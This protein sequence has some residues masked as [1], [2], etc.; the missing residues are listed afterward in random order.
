M[1]YQTGYFTDP[2]VEFI[3]DGSGSIIGVLSG[4]GKKST[5][6][7]QSPNITGSRNASQN[8]DGKIIINATA[9]NYTFTVPSGLPNSFGCALVQSS[10]G[11]VTAAAGAGV[12]F[13]GSTV[14]TSAA[15]Q[16]L[17]LVWAATDTYIVK[18]N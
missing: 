17:V 5:F 10:T 16:I 2:N 4:T 18:V 13:I 15:G 6:S 11:T 14:A 9:N 3:S 12:T 7:S 1:T 8:D